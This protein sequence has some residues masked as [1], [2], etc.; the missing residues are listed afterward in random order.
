MSEQVGSIISSIERQKRKPRYNIYIEDEFAFGVHEDIL[1]KHR[2]MKGQSIDKRRM[3]EILQDEERQ[4]AYLYSI[5]WLGARPRTRKEIFDRL[6][7]KGYEEGII[8]ETVKRLSEQNYVDDADYAKRWAEER[9]RLHKKGRRWIQ[10][11]LKEKGVAEQHIQDALTEVDTE[12]EWDSALVLARKKWHSG[13]SSSKDDRARYQKTLAYI[14]RRGYPM[15]LA[16]RAV[17]KI[18]DEADTEAPVEDAWE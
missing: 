7:S 8:E 9:V 18:A 15:D 5:R 2:L 14:L 11:E 12:A 17:R 4:Q 13:S 1:I 16:S 10:Q 6:K 3:E